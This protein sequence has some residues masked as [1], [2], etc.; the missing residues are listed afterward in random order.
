[1]SQKFVI[2]KRR[3]PLK[4]KDPAKCYAQAIKAKHVDIHEVVRRIAERSS[5]SMGEL[6]GAICEFLIELKNQLELG[7]TVNLG[8]L[9][10][11]RVTICT[12]KATD[13]PEKFSALTCIKKSRVRFTPGSM[14]RDMCKA[15]KYTLYKPEEEEEKDPNKPAGGKTDGKSDGKT[16][17]K[18][19]GN[20]P[21]KDDG[22][23]DNIPD[24]LS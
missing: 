1:M 5:Y 2:V 4:P 16:D 20:K 9:G 22:N 18:T 17:G 14:L 3:N 6:N 7:N 10:N 23:D 12:G 21:G 19:D 11:F 13:D 8:E 15:M 24:P